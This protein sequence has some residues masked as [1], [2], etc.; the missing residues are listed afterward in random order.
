MFTLF[1]SMADD[2]ILTVSLNLYRF[3]S[4]TDTADLTVSNNEIITFDFTVSKI[5]F[6]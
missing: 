3:L 4:E 2:R 1:I 5:E 6:L